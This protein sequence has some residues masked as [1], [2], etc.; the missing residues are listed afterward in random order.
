METMT[1]QISNF[2][3]VTKIADDGTLS[4]IASTA[5]MDRDGEVIEPSAFEGNLDLFRKNPVILSQHMHRSANGRPTIIGSA[6]DVVLTKNQLSFDMTFAS[7]DL[8]QEWKTLFDEKHARAFSVGFIPLKGETRE[9]KGVKAYHHTEVELL[10][11]S[12]VG[13]GSNRDALSRGMDDD[14]KEFIKS[15]L[16]L[17]SDAQEQFFNEIKD[18]FGPLLVKQ[19][20]AYEQLINPVDTEVETKLSEILSIFKQR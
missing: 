9:A 18:L 4:A 10:E 5:S 2:A 11:I 19:D 13:V 7:T 20:D 12:A 16:G 3:S 15:Q 1:K 17:I 8:G 14:I 6:K